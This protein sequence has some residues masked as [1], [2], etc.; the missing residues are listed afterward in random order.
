MP[1]GQVHDIDAE[2]LL[3]GRRMLD[4]RNGVAGVAGARLVEHL[5]AD[6]RHLRRN[7]FVLVGREIATAANE[8]RDM[9]AVTVAVRRRHGNTAAREIEEGF[10]PAVVDVLGDLDARIDHRDRNRVA[11]VRASATDSPAAF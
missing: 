4:R 1:K 6:E 9:R 11:R 5:V 10:D 8:P 7:P 2:L 3:V